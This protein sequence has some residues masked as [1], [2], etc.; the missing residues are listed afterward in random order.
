GPLAGDALASIGIRAEA[1]PANGPLPFFPARL[2][3]PEC[4]SAAGASLRRN[5]FPPI[6]SMRLAPR[7]ARPHAGAP[8]S[9]M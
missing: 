5:A 8:F 6:A 7:C 4:A 3:A 1:S 2:V 9:M